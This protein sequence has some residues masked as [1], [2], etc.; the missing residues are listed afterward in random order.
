M[1]RRKFIIGAGALASGSAA[2]VGTGAFS[3]MDADRDVNVDVVS[4]DVGLVALQASDNHDFVNQDN[5]GNLEI[6]V[7]TDEGA[8]GLNNN[9]RYQIG[10]LA[11]DGDADWVDVGG[12]PTEDYAFVIT[13]NDTQ[14]HEIGLWGDFP[15]IGGTGGF[16]QH[17]A[18]GM[19][20]D[21]DQHTDRAD[22]GGEVGE[23]YFEGSWP[24]TVEDVGAGESV[25]VSLLFDTTQD[26]VEVDEGD[27]SGTIT[28]SAD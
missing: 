11:E 3:A 1:E 6:D 2:A 24:F 18:A 9:A 7:P 23:E 25:Y 13:N 22:S 19:Y 15:A 16:D 8:E 17:V 5:E 28:I 20:Y 26:G 4:D 12:D 27:L 10:A 14:P 21:G